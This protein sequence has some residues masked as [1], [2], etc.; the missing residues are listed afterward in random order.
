MEDDA[1]PAPDPD[2]GV[3]LRPVGCVG[4]GVAGCAAGGGESL[5][6]AGWAPTPG[7]A[8]LVLITAT[9]ASGLALP[10][11][12]VPGD[13]RRIVR[14][15]TGFGLA[16]VVGWLP[17]ARAAPPE[18]GT[19]PS[20][21]PGGSDADGESK[22]ELGTSCLHAFWRSACVRHG[23]LARPPTS[24]DCSCTPAIPWWAVSCAAFAA[25]LS[26]SPSSSSLSW[27]RVRADE[28]AEDCPNQGKGT[29]FSKAAP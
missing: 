1:D 25:I 17:A 3:V 6:L 28:I 7:E 2:L 8:E 13:V 11:L 9:G 23:G 27:K 4:V 10:A 14:C 12:E 26:S 15:T 20:D 24:K 22:G 16:S 19:E 5:T 29:P 21:R 18:G